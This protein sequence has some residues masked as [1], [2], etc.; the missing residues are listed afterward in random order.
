M[1]LVKNLALVIIEV[2]IFL[3]AGLVGLLIFGLVILWGAG[4]ILGGM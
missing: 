4:L 1:N 3:A 2:L